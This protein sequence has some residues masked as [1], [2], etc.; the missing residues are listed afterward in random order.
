[1]KWSWQINSQ[2]DLERKSA[3]TVDSEVVC[4]AKLLFRITRWIFCLVGL[5]GY[6]IRILL[7]KRAM[8]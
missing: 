4:S 1:M 2:E 5:I 6:F 3:N 8:T 7:C